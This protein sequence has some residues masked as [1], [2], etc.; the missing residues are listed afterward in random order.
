MNFINKA[1]WKFSTFVMTLFAGLERKERDRR[2]KERF[3]RLR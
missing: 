2:L 3:L 1:K